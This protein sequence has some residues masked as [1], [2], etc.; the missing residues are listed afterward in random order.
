MMLPDYHIHT[1]LCGHACGDMAGYVEEAVKKGLVEI[2]FSDHVP[3][4]WLPAHQRDA[5]LAMAEA[6]FPE[7]VSRVLSLRETSPSIGI[8]LGV[9][10]DFVPGWEKE[11]AKIISSYPFDYV[12]GSVHYIDGWGFDNPGLVEEY[13]RRELKEIYRQYFNLICSAAK[14]GLFNI[15]AHPDL[16]KKFG[17]RLN[18]APEEL[19]RQTARAFAGSGVCVEVNTAGLRAPAGEIY[20]CLDFLRLCRIEGVSVSTG[21]DAHSPDLVGSNF[22]EAVLLLKEAGYKEVSIFRGMHRR[23]VKI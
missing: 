23:M 8:G 4:Y 17:Y 14:S 21:S 20:P 1:S 18:P 13:S 11:A 2:G 12:I 7:Y 6:S 10:V 22:D 9:E 16:V 15:I 19:Y 3:M 5:G